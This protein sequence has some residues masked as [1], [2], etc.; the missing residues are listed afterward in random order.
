MLFHLIVEEALEIFDPFRDHIKVDA[1][2]LQDKVVR[3][4]CF[5]R[6]NIVVIARNAYFYEHRVL[7]LKISPAKFGLQP[8]EFPLL[9]ELLQ[10]P[11]TSCLALA[12]S[13]NGIVDGG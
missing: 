8:M 7:T 4:I 12:Q 6:L 10:L 11:F 3:V 9:L 1:F 5:T 2:N 13:A